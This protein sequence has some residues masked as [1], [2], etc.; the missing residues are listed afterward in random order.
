MR[1]FD[2]A[3]KATPYLLQNDYAQCEAIVNRA[4]VAEDP[5]PFY[6]VLTSEFTNHPAEVAAYFDAFFEH[7]SKRMT[8]GAIYTETNGFAI[9]P[10]R[11]HFDLFGYTSDGGLDDPNW[12][13][14]WQSDMWPDC[15]LTGMED[16]QKVYASTRRGSEAAYLSSL[17]VVIKFQKLIFSARPMMKIGQIPVYSTGHDFEFIARC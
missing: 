12:I 3:E 4:L 11:W 2:V 14:D 10:G 6:M 5:S 9:N 8:V 17:L 1:W 15:T 16:L 13:S 7:E